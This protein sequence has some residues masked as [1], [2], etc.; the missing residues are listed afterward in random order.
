MAEENN[1]LDDDRFFGLDD[2]SVMRELLRSVKG[3]SPIS[4]A[5]VVDEVLSG[6]RAVTE[7]YQ[8]E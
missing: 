7:Q 1:R 2:M 5:P 6:E 4:L 8:F 3:L